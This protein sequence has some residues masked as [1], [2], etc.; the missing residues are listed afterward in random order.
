M[1]ARFYS[2]NLRRFVNSDVIIGEISNAI[3]LNRYAYA[4]GNPVS[5]FDP[6]GLCVRQDGEEKTE[7]V[8]TIA[9]FVELYVGG[10]AIPSWGINEEALNLGL[11]FLGLTVER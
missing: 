4:N 9:T 7:L 5:N 11:G 1:R 8:D 3:T 2:P 6:F 10:T